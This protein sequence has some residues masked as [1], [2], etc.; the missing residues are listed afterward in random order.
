MPESLVACMLAASLHFGIPPR[1]LPTIWQIER[2][3]N[4]VAVSNTNGSLDIGIMQINSLWIP[5]LAHIARLSPDETVHR[6]LQD[7]CFNVTASALI[8][9]SYLDETH[10]NLMQAIGDYHSHT[11]SLNGA[12]QVR[13]LQAARRLFQR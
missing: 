8:V 10:G 13:I 5:V 2:G 7:S 4:G 3:R 1:V 11:P 12:Y 9:R 6:L